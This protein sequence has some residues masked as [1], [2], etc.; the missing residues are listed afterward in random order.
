MNQEKSYIFL[1]MHF[2]FFVL[3]FSD[4]VM[5]E[6][7]LPVDTASRNT[8]FKYAYRKKMLHSTSLPI[9]SLPGIPIEK[10][11]FS[12]VVDFAPIYRSMQQQYSDMGTPAKNL[13]FT[14][15]PAG[16][17]FNGNFYRQPLIDLIVSASPAKNVSFA[18]EYAMSHFFTGKTG[19][20]SR[21]INVQNLLQFHGTTHTAYGNF[22]LSAGGGAMNYSLSPLTIYNKDF[23]E[24]MFEKLPWDW[25]TNSFNKYK[26]QFAYS[27][28]TTPTTMVSS[29]TQGFILEGA[30]LPGG[31]GFSAFYGRSSL[32]INPSRAE[33]GLISEIL[34]GKILYGTD[35]TYKFSFNYYHAY[36]FTDN[37]RNTKDERTIYT[38]DIKY[39]SSKYRFYTEAGIGK[40]LN[41]KS[42]GKFGKAITA[43]IVVYN[44]KI[45]MPFQLRAFRIDRQVTSL[46]SEVLN[47]NTSVVQG[48]YGSDT[49]Y[50]NSLYPG[51]LQEVNQMANNRQGLIFRI[52]KI[53]SDFRIEFG[54]SWS[55][56]IVN[57][58]AIIS[59]EHM[60]NAY[61]ASR[62]R[63]WYQYSG[64][65]HRI[66]NRFRRSIEVLEINHSS[67]TGLKKFNAADLS[68][69]Y[70]CKIF[71]R[72]FL[73]I[74]FT[75]AGSVGNSLSPLPVMSSESFLTTFYNELS[76]YFNLSKKITLLGFCGFQKNS[77]NNTTNLSPD[78]GKPM[79]QLGKGYGF[80]IDYDFDSNAGIFLRHR[81]LA[82]SDKNFL[83]DKYRGQETT[84]EIK[85][86][87]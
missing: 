86:F 42:E 24:P 59:F 79:D 38:A 20:T 67:N 53:F 17:Q 70:K 62:F 80:G 83:L 56:E 40:T 73:L 78:T 8:L 41:P 14:P 44:A 36:G 50:N 1:S 32:S 22:L 77:A 46:E 60:V 81:W 48:G 43:G 31:F 63:P 75:Y 34:A 29:A 82:H 10:I 33:K 68:I 15:Y 74:N 4:S 6:G 16:S 26:T 35:T 30:D 9:R 84:L 7:L 37:V 45:S 52:E 65:Y 25:H 58:S 3:F 66:G 71:N 47:S 2:F 55:E 72:E 87:F 61:S 76:A 69:K 57:N 11:S 12:G 64:P 13:E 54:N 18:V 21:K 49:V 51:Y 85:V 5:A 27:P 19:D 39:S 23:R 28:A